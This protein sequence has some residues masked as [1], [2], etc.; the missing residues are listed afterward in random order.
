MTAVIRV[1][2]LATTAPTSPSGVAFSLFFDA[3]ETQY[4][5]S[6]LASIDGFAFSISNGSVTSG[7][8][9]GAR[10]SFDL[11]RSEVRVHAPVSFSEDLRSGVRFMNIA[12]VSFRN[13][14]NHVTGG[15][16]VQADTAT[17]SRTYLAGR[18][19]CVAPGR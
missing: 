12:V 15:P 1:A 10:G 9:G 5:L 4:S 14:H 16:A 7:D 18:G 3:N 11:S 2:H 19:G 6:A 13:F 17:T 8:N